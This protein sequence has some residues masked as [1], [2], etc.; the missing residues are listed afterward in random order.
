MIALDRAKLPRS[1]IRSLRQVGRSARA[2]QPRGRRKA[3]RSATTSVSAAASAQAPAGVGR[4]R[5]NRSWPP[6]G[7]SVVVGCHAGRGRTPMPAGA[8]ILCPPHAHEIRPSSAKDVSVG[9]AG[10]IQVDRASGG[11]HGAQRSLRPAESCQSPEG[12]R[13]HGA[14][15]G[16]R[17]TRPGRRPQAPGRSSPD[18]EG[19][20]ERPPA[21]T[22]RTSQEAL[23][24]YLSLMGDR[25][26]LG[27][28]RRSGRAHR[29]GAHS[30]AA[31]MTPSASVPLRP[32]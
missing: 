13:G 27:P 7:R 5:A 24:W 8:P 11:V 6:P 12:T 16:E 21:S 26:V 29:H 28:E 17:P 1:R 10:G 4:A 14:E 20:T 9:M 18:P 30:R 22:G 32:R 19:S 23:A 31:A 25:V 15:R 3:G 2:G